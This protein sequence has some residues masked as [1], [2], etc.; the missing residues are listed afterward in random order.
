ML[1]VQIGLTAESGV[2]TPKTVFYLH[3][4]DR[5]GSIIQSCL[6]YGR[7]SNSGARSLLACRTLGPRRFFR[8]VQNDL[9]SILFVIRSEERRVGK[10]CRCSR[11]A[12]RYRE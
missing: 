12:D 8:K 2:A 3:A 5:T 4:P 1:L 9:G 10:E 7:D 6:L 11:A